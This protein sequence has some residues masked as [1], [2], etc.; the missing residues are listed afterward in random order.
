MTTDRSELRP[1][2]AVLVAG[3][4]CAGKTTYIA[5]QQQPGDIVLDFDAIARELGSPASW[6]HPHPYWDQ[7][8]QVM[9]SR[10]GELPGSG[11]HTAWVIRSAATPKQRAFLSRLIGAVEC[12][13]VNPGLAICLGRARDDDRPTGTTDEIHRWYADYKPWS[14]DKNVIGY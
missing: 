10:M 1:A 11:P 5:E 9:R 6:L 4:S 8:E 12:V 14:R 13:V 3:P 7:A 2:R